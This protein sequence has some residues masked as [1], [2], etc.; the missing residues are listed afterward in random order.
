MSP[1]R[2]HRGHVLTQCSS[3]TGKLPTRFVQRCAWHVRSP[4]RNSTHRY[5][6]QREQGKEET[7]RARG[8]YIS[9]GNVV[10]KVD[11]DD[12]ETRLDGP[13]TVPSQSIILPNVKRLSLQE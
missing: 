11:I 7:A 2:D 10:R 13:L 4:C 5:T 9:I 12:G 1:R 6:S 8:R 3:P